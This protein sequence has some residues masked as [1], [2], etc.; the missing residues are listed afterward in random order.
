MNNLEF[1][2]KTIMLIAIAVAYL[3]WPADAVPDFI[4]ILGQAD[5]LLV[6][7]ASIAGMRG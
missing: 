5:D 4:P 3:I 2:P 7:L 6:G 1:S